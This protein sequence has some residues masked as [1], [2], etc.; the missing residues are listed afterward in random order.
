M[1]IPMKTLAVAAVFKI[2]L[3]FIF[4]GIPKYNIFGAVIGIV[5]FL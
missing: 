3:N 4:V 5:V 2:L 1:D